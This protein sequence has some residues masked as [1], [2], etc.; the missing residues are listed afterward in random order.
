M[1]L[2]RE[3]DRFGHRLLDR[4]AERNG[5]WRAVAF[6]RGSGRGA[7]P[8]QFALR[9]DHDA[10][11][12]GRPGVLRIHAM[13]RPRFLQIAIEAVEDRAL[14][15]GLEVAEEEH[16]L[17]P[18][19]TDERERL[20]VGRHPGRDRTA[21]PA[22]D[23]PLAPGRE[24]AGEDRVDDAVRIAVVVEVRAGRD[25]ATV[26]ERAS[27]GR[28]RRL[29]RV[30]LDAGAFGHLHAIGAAARGTSRSRRRRAIARRRNAGARRCIG[31][32]ATRS[33]C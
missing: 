11:V 21:G 12:V 7:H 1:N 30:L 6:A 27:V 29:T 9:P 23:H 13:N 4:G 31:R 22:G 8:P 17:E 3:S 33:D 32:R 24:I 19:A 16:A 15:A 20:A 26:I 18:H 14:G 10:A 5:D 25:V 2:R 28:E